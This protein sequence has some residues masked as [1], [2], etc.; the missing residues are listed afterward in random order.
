ME[1]KGQTEFG[2]RGVYKRDYS[3]TILA[4]ILP[5]IVR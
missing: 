2:H 3:Y 5:T 1:V 4:V